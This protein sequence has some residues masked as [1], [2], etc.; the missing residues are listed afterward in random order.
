MKKKSLL[1]YFA[2]LALI[3]TAVYANHFN[4]SFHFDDMHSVL[5]NPHIR[6][7]KNIPSFFTDGT[8]SSVLPQ[9]AAYRPIVTTS[10]AIDYA[11]GN[12]YT[13]AAFHSSTFVLFLIQGLLMLL[14]FKK[15]LSISSTNNYVVYV[16]LFA[17]AW[18]LLHPA[19]AETINYVIAR[20]DVQST[21]AVVAGFVLYIYS[22]FCRKTFL[23]LI[24]V[25]IGALAKPP[26]IMF[27]P[28]FFFYVL[29]FETQ[30]GLLDIFKKAHIKQF[31]NAIKRSLP[32]FV[33]CAFLYVLINKLTPKTWEPGG[34]SPMQYLI[35][36]PYVILHYFTVFF[37][38]T[39]LSA[40]SD[41]GILPSIKD[42]RFFIGC[43]FILIMM[44][45]AIYTSKNALLRPISFGIVWFFIALV[46]TSSIIPLGEVLNDHRMYFPFI[47]L[48][49]S[50]SWAIGLFVFKIIG[51]TT[52]LSLKY[53]TL[54]LLPALVLLSACAY[55]TIK[56]N[57]VW[58]TEESLW[59]NVTV[60]SP[61][62]GRG[63][64]NYGL[65]KV[66]N[67]EYV[68]AEKYFNK[69]LKLVPNYSYLY[70]NMGV[71]KE[72]M[73]DYTTAENDYLK[74]LQL[75]RNYANSYFFYGQFLYNQSRFIEAE[76]ALQNA[77]AL[78]SSYLPSRLLLLK[79]YPLLGEWEQ[80][81]SMAAS[82]AKIA[83]D[84]ED[85]LA[86]VEY[87][88]KKQTKAEIEAERVKKAPSA[89]KYLNLSLEFYQ[90]GK[91]DKCIDAANEA[92]KLKPDY[93]EAYNN[94]GCAY[95][96][97]SQFDKAKEVFN[98]ALAIK[99]DYPLAKNNLQLAEK[100]QHNAKYYTAE[101]YINQ[102]L[103]YYNMQQYELC[104]AACVSALTIKPNYDL[105]Y[106]NLCASYIKLSRWDDAITVGEKGMKINP[107]NTLLKNNLAQAKSEKNKGKKK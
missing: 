44:G 34:N 20:S 104:I 2:L 26:A 73:G 80:L 62:N 43:A 35:T 36:Q 81:Q 11:L 90:E 99:P 42:A 4:N 7:L 67:G 55:G 3:V 87:A 48:A 53:K 54:I 27:A 22:P 105:A 97:L 102:S 63:M 5:D 16:A 56:R 45:I 83:P 19:I 93:L 8:T 24:P 1:N 9:N 33:F 10:L 79:I 51:N 92:L 95:N 46:P 91:Y 49:I 74:A 84:N 94:I 15:V 47:G 23:Y 68:E 71:L 106:N 41:W 37:W 82:T 6:S 89:V 78:S 59:F 40:D 85:V 88:K 77:V 103:T 65:I 25:G 31:W 64:M 70:V 58:Q 17:T 50:A 32:S 52:T 60:K 18:Y 107:N 96:N 12:G 57:A 100:H 69:A 98:K 39:G 75:G 66:S 38:P 14:L 76:A 61:Q 72:K 30:I 21:F 101:E 28:L 86:A 13:L 29:F